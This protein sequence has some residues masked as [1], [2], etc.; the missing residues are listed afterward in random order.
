MHPLAPMSTQSMLPPQAPS[1]RSRLITLGAIAFLPA[2]LVIIADAYLSWKQVLRE[3]HNHVA[4]EVALAAA[5]QRMKIKTV[6]AFLA[7]I[8]SLY[9]A[10]QMAQEE[11]GIRLRALLSHLDSLANIGFLDEQGNII[12][13]GLPGASDASFSDRGY[14]QDAREHMKF[15]VSEILVGGV[16]GQR[17]IAFAYPLFGRNGN[18]GG[19]VFATLKDARFPSLALLKPGTTSVQFSY[20]DRKGNI[21]YT[22][23]E[24]GNPSVEPLPTEELRDLDADDSD[25]F[26]YYIDAFNGKGFLAALTPIKIGGETIGYIKATL[27]EEHIL[28]SWRHSASRR[29]ASLLLA[30]IGGLF[31]IWWFLQRW[32]LRDLLRLVLFTKSARDEVFP[33][34]I[35][36]AS[37]SETEAAMK[38]VADMATTLRSQNE[39]LLVLQKHLSAS[40]EGLEHQVQERTRE[41]ERS[42]RS[43]RKL[44]ESLPQIVWTATTE[45]GVIYINKTW[46]TFFEEPKVHPLGH[47]WI[48]Y[49]HPEDVKR[50]A[51][52][53][54][55]AIETAQPFIGHFRLRAITGEYRYYFLHSAPLLDQDGH[56]ELWM[57]VGTDITD[58]KNSEEA[59]KAANDE[60]E[61]FS[62]SVSHDL[63][64]P[65][66]AIRDYSDL[67]LA[68]CGDETKP[69]SKQYL[70]RI[71]FNSNHTLGLLEDL[72]KLA[73]LSEIEPH[74]TIVDLSALCDDIVRTLRE[75]DPARTVYVRVNQEMKTYGDARL[76]RVVLTNLLSNA[77]KFTG[78]VPHPCIFVGQFLRNGQVI[79][80][81]KD[82]GVGF[83]MQYSE[84]LFRVFQRLH[85]DKEYPGTGI[86]LAIC[87]KVIM[88]HSGKLWA[89]SKP[90]KGATFFF[91]IC[92]QKIG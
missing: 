45:E 33:L 36:S 62:Y 47:Q 73:H 24:G 51:E 48:D 14:F 8:S 38:A 16:S 69:E 58:F 10:S 88:R 76:L 26:K 66:C 20:F 68:E 55:K 12:C 34:K 3:A 40:K 87:Q 44:A 32:F 72:L 89:R 28:S 74:F 79:Y 50:A 84:K 91:T 46:G 43:Y 7:G 37:L 77:W 61:A 6:R 75:Q 49:F 18:F 64:A 30:L 86:G 2:L 9:P 92:N 15:S 67:L 71:N 21:I 90:N 82:N 23:Q 41:L 57:G 56:I 1:L 83:D 39:E 78:H 65:L 70:E 29:A 63:R 52:V 25:A 13:S 19:V 42:E 11:C 5:S 85:S 4:E 53:W 81:L 80:F 31:L 22:D 35:G 60:L 17:A 27:R 54:E 59:L